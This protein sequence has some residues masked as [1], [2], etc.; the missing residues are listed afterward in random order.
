MTGEKSP[1]GELDVRARVM[2]TI[3]ELTKD[4][5]HKFATPAEIGKALHLTAG[6][7]RQVIQEIED[8]SGPH[9]VENKHHAK[10]VSKG[11]MRIGYRLHDLAVIKPATALM[12]V[13]LLKNHRS[14]FVKRKEF[15]DYMADVHGMARAGVD[16]RITEGIRAGYIEDVTTLDGT[17]RGREQINVDLPYIQALAAKYK[18]ASSSQRLRARAADA[19]QRSTKRRRKE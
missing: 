16:D 18:P 17:I 13:E 11:R 4:A 2:L 9:L 7:V 5:G 8:L 15:V 6:Y 14:H 3:W 10:G 1:P 19:E 12:L